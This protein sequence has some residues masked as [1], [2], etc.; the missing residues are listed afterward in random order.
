MDIKPLK[1]EADYEAA[2][3]RIEELWGIPADS[4]H[5]DELE[6]LLALTGVYEKKHHHIPP[7]DCS[8]MLEF[9][10]D[11]MGLT[12]EEMERY[13]DVRKRLPQILSREADLPP[14][15]IRGI[16]YLPTLPSGNDWIEPCEVDQ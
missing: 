10:M 5:A 15:I 6:V 13:L 8:T 1:T 7:P 9:R 2:M 3:A 16:G 4:P 14:E 11:Q 12:P